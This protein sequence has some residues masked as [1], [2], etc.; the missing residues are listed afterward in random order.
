[1]ANLWVALLLIVGVFTIVHSQAH[2]YSQTFL[3]ENNYHDSIS[4][5]LTVF[6]KGKNQVTNLIKVPKKGSSPPESFV[7]VSPKEDG[8]YPILFFIHGTMLTNEAYS[9]LFKFI[10]SHGFIVV[11]PKLFRAFP[12]P[13]LPSHQDEINRAAAVANWLPSNLQKILQNNKLANVQPNFNS[14]AISGH[15]RGGKSAFALALGMS[16][17]KLTV[18]ISALIGIDPVAGASPDD[19][20]K[21]YVLT[22]HDNSFK[23]P[24]PV[25]VIGTGLGNSTI[26]CAPNNVSHQQF[27]N[28]CKKSSHFVIN[29]YG[30]MEMLDDFLLDPL[31]ITMSVMC[32]QSFGPK[33]TMRRTLGGVMVAFM[34]TYF[35]GDGGQYHAIMANPSL[36]PTKLFVEEKGNFGFAPNHA[37]A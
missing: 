6:N 9:E 13:S 24:V 20:T 25:T 10:A 5:D 37:Q 4:E 19:R 3:E 16:E 33:A 17:T 1:M 7:V 32:K 15:S 28:E 34:N 26:P 31:A 35:R 8:V 30:H 14:F 22:Y 36:A 11:A 12:L 2:Q 23:L 21:P 29:K 27:Y 18:K